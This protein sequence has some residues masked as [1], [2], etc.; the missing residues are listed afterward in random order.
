MKVSRWSGRRG[1][2]NKNE[3]SPTNFE[4]GHS[5]KGRGDSGHLRRSRGT[6]PP[7]W[8]HGDPLNRVRCVLIRRWGFRLCGGGG[9]ARWSREDKSWQTLEGLVTSNISGMDAIGRKPR[10]VVPTFVEKVCA[11]TAELR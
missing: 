8:C 7:G 3:V 2:R 10:E 5:D 11:L 4:R 9:W 1:L 6:R